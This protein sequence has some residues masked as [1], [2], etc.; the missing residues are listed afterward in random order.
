MSVTSTNQ[1]AQQPVTT[2]S[3]PNTGSPKTSR[4]P[5][6]LKSPPPP[7]TGPSMGSVPGGKSKG[8]FK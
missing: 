2:P 4:Q 3:E 1:I 5:T 6:Q 8:L 7:K